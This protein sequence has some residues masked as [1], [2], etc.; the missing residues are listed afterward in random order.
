MNDF[1]RRGMLRATAAAGVGAV[2]VPGTLAAGAPVASAAMECEHCPCPPAELTGRIVR[3]RDPGYADASL[4]W[5]ELFTHFPLVIVFAQNTQDVVNALKWARQNDVALRVR[6]GR[7]SL[8][9]WSNVDNGIVIDISELKS[10]EIDAAARITTVGAGLS[11]L[12][13]VTALAKQNFAVTTGTEG[14]VGLSGATLGGGFGFL[15]RWLGMACDSLVEAEV[16]VAAGAE[17]A[18]VVKASLAHN[19]DLLWALRGAGNG[20]FGI[21]TSLTYKVAPLN[22]VT[23]VQ[24]T[25]EGIG[26]LH[27]V[28]DAWQRT[29]PVT[30]NRLGTQLEVHKNQ[31][32]LFGVLAE[33]TPDEAKG[34][35]APILS[36]GN[37]TVTVQVGNWG[38]VYSGFQIPT[39]NEPAN[40]KFFSQFTRKP[41]P[42]EAIGVIASFMQ[43]A[44]TDDSNF[45]TQAFG[46]A[47]RRRPDGGTAFPHRDALFYSE[48]GAGWGK[49]G[50]QPGVCDPLTPQAQAWIAEFSQAMRPYVSGAYVNVPNIGMQDWETAYWRSN[51]DRLRE[52]KTKYDPRNVFQYEQS[53]TPA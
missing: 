50:S 43:N 2:V 30:D 46:G 33:G 8:E 20:N 19:S 18:K 14:T 16:V 9:G 40:W 12:E 1:S 13:A 37:P 38:E 35:L 44:P 6:S 51:F 52:I 28:F 49:R 21:V 5:D 7:H 39:E 47:V 42:K 3:P 36:V 34:L 26:D 53:I 10:V 27:G 11:Q 29:A 31:I 4:G 17:C 15:T 25:W 24:A 23:Y 45:F 32:L 22:S 41:F 48:P